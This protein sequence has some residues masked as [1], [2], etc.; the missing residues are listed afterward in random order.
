MALNV[1]KNNGVDY[2][3]NGSLSADLMC[4]F[5]R[6]IR[7]ENDL[8]AIFSENYTIDNVTMAYFTR[9]ADFGAVALVIG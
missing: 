3:R 4:L 2:A 8:P 5:L 7:P 9:L 6:K 1:L